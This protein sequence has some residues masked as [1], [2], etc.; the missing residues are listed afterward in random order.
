[1]DKRTAE[2]LHEV[3]LSVPNPHGLEVAPG[4]WKT[5]SAADYILI[6]NTT[7]MDV[8]LHTGDSV[9]AVFQGHVQHRVCRSC[10]FRDSEVLLRE[11]SDR[12]ENK[13]C[14]LSCENCGSEDTECYAALRQD[15]AG[16]ASESAAAAS[17][18]APAS[19]GTQYSYAMHP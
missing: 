9:A 5:G 10:G 11:E 18:A 17:V 8:E 12:A 15:S 16:W 6:T 3:V 1:M 14:P 19:V 7:E 2:S 13:W 4:V